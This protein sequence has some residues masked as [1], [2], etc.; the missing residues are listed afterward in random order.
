MCKISKIAKYPLKKSPPRDYEYYINNDERGEF[1]ADVRIGEKTVFEIHG[2]EIFED[3]YMNH[4]DDLIGLYDYLVSLDVFRSC[5]R[6][7]KGQ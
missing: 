2:I 1:H 6:L 5:D 4:P 3:G 7:F